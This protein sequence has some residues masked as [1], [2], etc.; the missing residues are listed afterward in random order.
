MST[1]ENIRRIRELT[2]ITQ[3]ELADIAG[4]SRSAVS[5]WEI[6]DAEPRMGAVQRIA[7]HFGIN[8]SNIIENGGM[9][10]MT[11]GISGRI[12]E[13]KT[14]QIELSDDE[15][16]LIRMYRASDDRGRMNIMAVAKINTGMEGQIQTGLDGYIAI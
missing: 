14:D 8:K 10:G 6:G 5:L 1:S 4:V 16:E 13:V 15:I 11:A 9:D 3:Q 7:D 12:Y 2:N